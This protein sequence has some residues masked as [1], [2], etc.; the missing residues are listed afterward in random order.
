[1]RLLHTKSLKLKYFVDDE[2]PPY[3]ILSHRWE[4]EEILFEDIQTEHWP[5]KKGLDKVKKACRQ[6]S[7]DGLE[8]IWIDTCCIDKRSS[9]ELSEAINSMFNWYYRSKVCYAYLFDVPDDNTKTFMKSKWFTRGWTLQEL[10]APQHVEFFDNKWR[11][12][13]D[14]LSYL[15]PIVEVTAIDRRVL[16]RRQHHQ[17]CPEQGQVRGYPARFCKACGKRSWD[18][19]QLLSS[20]SVATLMSWAFKR[21]TTRV[22]DAAYSL[23]G[24]FNV[25]MPLLYGEQTKAFRRLQEEIIRNSNDQSILANEH[26]HC[27]YA[28]KWVEN[29]RQE[30]MS[31][32][33]GHLFPANVKAFGLTPFKP[34]AL[35]RWSPTSRYLSMTLTSHYLNI[36]LHI[37]PCWWMY[38]QD[39]AYGSK[40]RMK[41][42]WLGILA[43]VYSDDYLSRPALLLDKLSSAHYDKPVFTRTNTRHHSLIRLLP[44]VQPDANGEVEIPDK[45]QRG[46][47]TVRFDPSRIEVMD[48]NL[49]LRQSTQAEGMQKVTMNVKPTVVQPNGT[50]Y[51]IRASFP[52][53][54]DTA[55]RHIDDEIAVPEWSPNNLAL[56]A[57][58]DGSNHGFFVAYGSSGRGTVNSE[59]LKP[60]AFAEFRPWCRL[61]AWHE[62]IPHREFMPQKGLVPN[63]QVITLQDMASFHSLYRRSLRSI[64]K[65]QSQHSMDLPGRPSLRA[66]AAIISTT[67][68]GQTVHEL[69]T[70]VWRALNSD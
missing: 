10:I 59:A 26:Y 25:N 43:C 65:T 28:F 63:Q 53:Q 39:Y 12:I 57:V 8:Y 3:A 17:H 1:M 58:D 31:D 13:G 5:R 4:A 32:A 61:L 20:F 23:L 48:I 19:R 66:Q 51:Q 42:G 54:E 50:T 27:F 18:F 6:A 38:K 52:N 14:R 29:G 60:T 40:P 68:L 37:C 36:D 21:E 69:E 30:S 22:E 70:S 34:A 35:E 33:F 45:S 49:L 55:N 11:K 46:T 67:F 24:L 16:D 56:L 2:I 62:V 47:L 15:E 44:S 64:D 7:A 41:P 9:A